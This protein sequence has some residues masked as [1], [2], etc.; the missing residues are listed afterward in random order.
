MGKSQGYD[1]YKDSGVEWLGAIPE[2]WEVIPIKFSLS[3]PITDGP[4]ETPDLL[5]DGI[6]FISAEAIKNDQINFDKKRG[7][8][9]LEEHKRFSKKYK[10]KYGDV[11]M[12]KSGATTGNVARVQT[13]EEFNIWSPLAALRPNQEKTT[14]DFLF[15][16]IKSKPF[17][18]SVEQ[19]W[20]F[21][22]QQ[23]IGMGIIANIRITFPPL[24][25]QEKIA[26]FL[27]YKTKQIDDLIAKKET[28]I[29][30][31]DEKRTAL[32]SHAVTKGLDVN[33]PMKDSGIE[34]LG[35][36]P[37]HWEVKRLKQV[38][39]LIDGDI[40][41]NYPNENDLQDEGIPFLSTENIKFNTFDFSQRT[42]FITLEK[43]ESLSRGK[44]I[45]NDLVVTMRGT[46]GQTALFH[47]VP[48]ETA[49]INAQ[50]II[51]RPTNIFAEFLKY[52]SMS[53]LWAKQL[54]FYSY[55]TAQQQ[56][57][58]A[59]LGILRLGFPPLDEQEKIAR[60]LDQKTAQIDEQKTKIQQAI[61]LLKEYRTA[62]ITNA[63]TGKIDVRKIT[64]PKI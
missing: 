10:P 7:Y 15:Y 28:L 59:I 36:I 2:H 35:A 4:H 19:S 18:Y 22:T 64:I 29:E 14:T 45:Q 16:V 56:L 54:D 3:M 30:K 41:K 48:Y 6:P 33:V 49:F 62:L 11:Y 39:K 13:H 27:D 55:G 50:M 1:K 40:V 51:V 46:I 44:L 20:S 60:F 58:G 23:N 5:D 32:I 17:F 26:R 9:S 63:V 25:E 37:N 21:G 47:K 52:I 57:S 8:I 24:E 53:V 61:D 42:K 31:L 38:T 43:F 34:W 12:V